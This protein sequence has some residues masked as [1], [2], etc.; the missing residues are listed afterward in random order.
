LLFFSY[1]RALSGTRVQVEQTFGRLKR[2]F[3]A[4]HR[5]LRIDLDRVPTFIIACAILHN[6]AIDMNEPETGD[7]DSDDSESEDEQD[8]P[9]AQQN[10]TGNQVRQ[11]IVNAYFTR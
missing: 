7:E 5:E 4:L 3:S 1:N 6:V 11:T 2:R 10:Q 8:Q 9:A